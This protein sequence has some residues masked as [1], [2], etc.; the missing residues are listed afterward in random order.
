MRQRWVFLCALFLASV[1]VSTAAAQGSTW[2]FMTIERPPFAFDHNGTAAGFSIDLMHAIAGQ[3]GRE[4]EFTF[5]PDFPTMLRAVETAGFDGA[6]ANISITSEREAVM[7][8]S[9]PIFA[10]GLQ[11]M[12]AG[13]ASGPVI[14]DILLRREF[15]VLVVAGFGA[16]FVLGLLMWL[17]ERGRQSYF[18][19][20]PG[21]ALFPSFWWALNLVVNGGFEQ[22]VPRSLLGRALAVL[23]V[24]SSLFL[25]SVFVAKITA[26]LTVEAISGSIQTLSDL[27]GRRVG[28]TEG[29]T[30][31]A[32]LIDRDLSH[33]SYV[34]YSELMRAF[35]IGELDAVL[36]DGPILGH[37][38]LHNPQVEAYLLPQVFRPEDYGIALPPGSLLR[39]AINRALL[40]MVETGDYSRLKQTWF[41]E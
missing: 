29:S 16:L 31:S 41:V 40:Q 7:D 37:Y 27:D 8:F 20:R 3:L 25:V 24:V 36:F 18:D 1:W 15:V 17:C 23:M 2:R 26:A 39:E 32:F 5:A 33:K 10:S 21:E 13:S 19:L 12:V 28:T 9:R 22:H 4:V 6:I 35:E 11:I 30:S 38:L 34:D 14:W